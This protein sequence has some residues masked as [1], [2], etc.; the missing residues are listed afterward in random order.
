MNDS[1]E[2]I[3]QISHH[4]HMLAVLGKKIGY[5]NIT[6][7][8]KWREVI[9]AGILGHIAFKK[10]SAGKKSDKYGSDAHDPIRDLNAEYK[11]KAVKES[12]LNNLFQR[13]KNKKTNSCYTPIVISGVYNGAY[14]YEIV[15]KYSKHDHYFGVFYEEMCVLIIKVKTDYVIETLQK[16]VAKMLAKKNK[17]TTNG[18][19]V[20]VSLGNTHLYEV[21]YRNE[22][23]FKN[24]VSI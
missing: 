22:E 9:M 6:D 21:V 1:D 15:N 24:N 10:M 8:T 20:A 13:I 2:I 17:T 3:K 4:A 5:E 19:S 12:E 18:N 7:K 23:W 11:S 16:G 14:N